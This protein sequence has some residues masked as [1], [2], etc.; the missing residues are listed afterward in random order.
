MGH[1]SSSVIQYLL[2]CLLRQIDYFWSHTVWNKNLVNNIPTFQRLIFVL[3]CLKL[4][5]L[6]C[7]FQVS[8]F[9]INCLH[10]L[11]YIFRSS[12]DKYSI[13]WLTQ[14]HQLN[15]QPWNKWLLHCHIIILRHIGGR[16]QVTPMDSKCKC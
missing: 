11:R 16:D 2:F 9:V 5:R 12:T 8:W 13:L 14:L 7:N 15:D 1:G 10:Q 3:K 4:W 6:Q